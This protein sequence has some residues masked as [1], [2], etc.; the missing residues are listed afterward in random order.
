MLG[1]DILKKRDKLLK[2]KVLLIMLAGLICLLILQIK[3]TKSNENL[4]KIFRRGYQE[5]SEKIELLMQT[6]G[7]SPYE[8]TIDVESLEYKKEEV[9]SLYPEFLEKLKTIILFENENLS[10]I[11]SDMNLVEK[12][13]GYPFKIHWISSNYKV[14]TQNGKILTE[15]IKSMG[16]P[17][18]LT[19]KIKYLEFEKERTYIADVFE[20]EKTVEEK[21]VS[22]IKNKLLEDEKKNRESKVLELPTIVDG[23]EIKWK[24]K[25]KSYGSDILIFFVLLIF[26]IVLEQQLKEKK[27]LKKREQDMNKIYPQIISKLTLL[28]CAGY[29]LKKAW[30]QMVEDYKK[31]E[32]KIYAYEQMVQ[33]AQKMEKGLPEGIAYEEFGILCQQDQF[34]KLGILL[35]QNLKRGNENI[36]ERMKEEARQ[37]YKMRREKAK[38]E[39]EKAQTKLLLPMM[40]LLMLVLIV[41]V[42]PVFVTM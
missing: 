22:K 31:K 20:V 15:N 27:E 32:I 10:H 5:N 4:T 40:L 7:S 18:T 25:R 16:N 28:L 1:R 3:N 23:K 9:E 41:I 30:S 37:A 34:R 19:A 12:V 29:T 6:E 26:L 36:I 42:T 35:S 8:I 14:M 17:I 21:L 33:I 2:K 38:E 24:K 39:G 13:E 11:T